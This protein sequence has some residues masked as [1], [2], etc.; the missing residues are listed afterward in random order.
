MIKSFV[1]YDAR[2]LSEAVSFLAEHR[3]EAK[4]LAVP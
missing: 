3:E 4:V 1:P 2:T